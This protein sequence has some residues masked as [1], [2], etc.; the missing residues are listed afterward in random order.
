MLKLP[1]K[2]GS[3]IEK[4]RTILEKK[5]NV[6]SSSMLKLLQFANLVISQYIISYLISEPI[7]TFR[8]PVYLSPQSTG[9]QQNSSYEIFQTW[10]IKTILWVSA[11][12]RK[13]ENRRW[14]KPYQ[15][16]IFRFRVTLSRKH[17]HLQCHGW[18]SGEKTNEVERALNWK[19][20]HNIMPNFLAEAAPAK[21]H[22][23]WSVC[24]T[25]C[26]FRGE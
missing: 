8:K 11:L 21:I 1:I 18:E 23:L 9:L 6:T 14:Q 22:K 2:V 12:R 20:I 13:T 17:F 10:A 24:V 7:W 5:I 16:F 4:I 26:A 19:F 25:F 15:T 3:L